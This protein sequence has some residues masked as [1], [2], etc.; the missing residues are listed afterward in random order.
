MTCPAQ[1]GRVSDTTSFAAPDVGVQRS[2]PWGEAVFKPLSAGLELD[3]ARPFAWNIWSIDNVAFGLVE[4]IAVRLDSSFGAAACP[5]IGRCQ[6]A[7]R[8]TGRAR[9][10]LWRRAGYRRGNYQTLLSDN[11]PRHTIVT[12]LDFNGSFPSTDADGKPS[13]SANQDDDLTGVRDPETQLRLT[14]GSQ[15]NI[16]LYA[17]NRLTTTARVY[18]WIDYNAD[19]VF[20]NATERAQADVP[21]VSGTPATL[22][23]VTLTFP[24]VPSGFTGTTYA[25]FRLSTDAAAASPVGPASDGEVQDHLVTISALGAGTAKSN[26]RVDVPNMLDE[27]RFGQSLA[28]LG[29]LDGDGIEDLAVGAH[30][31]STVGGARGAVHILFMNADQTVKSETKLTSGRNGAPNLNDADFFGFS[32]ANIGDF[33]NDGIVD[34]AV[35][36][37]G[38]DTV[39]TDGG[40]FYVMTLNRD[41]T[42]KGF[43][44]NLVN[45]AQVSDFVGASL[46]SLGDLDGDG[47]RD[48]AV[49]VPGSNFAGTDRGVVLV[50]FLNANG[51]VKTLMGLGSGTGGAPN[52]NDGD[53][54]GNELA[55]LGTAG[56]DADGNTLFEL[57]VGAPRDN[58]G[59]VGRGAVY[60]LTLKRDGFVLPDFSVKLASG[61]NGVPVLGDGVQFGVGLANFGF[62]GGNKVLAVGADGD[63]VA[64]PNRGAVYL[65]TLNSANRVA[66]NGVRKFSSGVG[67]P[68]LGDGDALGGAIVALRDVDG[69]GVRELA[70][71]AQ[72][73]DTGGTNRGTVHILRL[74]ASLGV[75]SGGASKIVSGVSGTPAGSRFGTSTV[76]LGDI[77][78]DGVE[79]LAVGSQEENSGRGAV[80]ILL[81]DR[82]GGVKSTQVLGGTL[83][84]NVNDRFGT[85]LAKLPDT[86]GDGVSELVVGAPFDDTNGTD[87]GAVYLLRL[88]SNGTLKSSIKLASGVTGMPTL[89]NND[90]FGA[91]LSAFEDFNTFGSGLAV[92]ATGDNGFGGAI[93]LIRSPNFLVPSVVGVTK[94]ASGVNGGPTLTGSAGFGSS[95]ASIGDVD[96]DG[97]GDLAVGA[98]NDGGSGAVHILFLNNGR[99]VRSST[100][101]GNGTNG[102]PVLVG[103]PNFG[104]S[105]APLGDID[106][107]GVPDVAIGAHF[108]S[109]GGSNRGAVFV[110][111]LQRNGAAKSVTKIASGLGGAPQLANDSYFGRTIA[112]L[113]DIN[114]D[115]VR[116]L[117]VG[118]RGNTSVGGTVHLLR[119]NA[120]SNQAPTA[121]NLSANTIAENSASGTA[122][123]T[124]TT[125][126]PDAGNTFTYS[127]LNPGVNVDNQAFS[128]VGNQLRSFAV[129]DFEAKASYSVVVRTTDQ[130]GLFFDRTFTVNVTNVNETPTA[131]NLSANT[132]AENSVTGTVIGTFTSTDPDAGNT[133]TY[134]L[135]NPGVNIDN[136][137]FSIVGNQLRSFAVFNFETKST[138]SVVVRTTDQGGLFFDRTFTVN[139]TDVNEVI[140]NT[141]PALDASGNPFA[142]LG[143][144][145]R[146]STEMRQGVLV[147]DILARGAGGNPISDPDAGALRG[148]ALTAVDQTLGN[149]QY[150]LVT[151]NPQES[152]WVNVDAAGALSDTS[153]LLLPTTARLRFTTGR[154]P[155]H[156][157]A[158]FFLSV[159]SKL[160]AGLTFRAWDQTSG[161][162]GGRANTSTNGGTSAFSAATE[163]SKVYFEVRLFRSFNPNASLNVYTLEAEFNALTSGAFQDRSTNAFTGFT[164]LLSPVPE[165]GTS[166]LF[167][168]YFGIQFNDDGTET[169]MGYRYLTS[170]GAE[171]TFLES[172]GPASKRP[173]REGT[174]F[175]ELGV[176]NGTATI[177]YVFTTQ[178]PGTSQLTQIYRT[179]NVN[180]PTRPPGTSEG[181]T[182]TSFKPQENGDHVYTTN[183]AFEMSKFGTWRIES[184][185]GFVRELNPNPVSGAATAAAVAA[186]TGAES[187]ESAPSVGS[188]TTPAPARV[189]SAIPEAAESGVATSSFLLSAS[190][191]TEHVV[192]L[193]AIPSQPAVPV[194]PTPTAETIRAVSA[195]TPP[196]PA[197]STS[198]S[199][200]ST[201]P[202]HL[203][204]PD[205]VWPDAVFAD[206]AFVTGVL[207]AILPC[208]HS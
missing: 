112:A 80:R 192:R 183:T 90:R 114:G 88:N 24:A 128:I 55:F 100:R 120:A 150:T 42:V 207:T 49:G 28:N 155:H 208:G 98:Y 184:T 130:G 35:G 200:A 33:D 121:L 18:G 199:V 47:V 108:E 27:A 50:A 129:F 16:A 83:G 171:A 29:D 51:T 138:Y 117:A 65:L 109:T 8:A 149:F 62:V 87:R 169:D 135:L 82:S 32:V 151:T 196:R 13:A 175:R 146:Q 186:V 79:D 190:G 123:G 5:P 179:D 140:P 89:A 94:I 76:S 185:R 176:S 180:K 84:L 133:F 56:T 204:S 189:R 102:G 67:L 77:D 20:D 203:N 145:S 43:V 25:R 127:L 64:G 206:L 164:V 156:A 137:A 136:Q 191:V 187:I 194:S 161:A 74:N 103:S 59:G 188:Q 131:L 11:G 38:D 193:V 177:G 78:G 116:D 86:D 107:D 178:Q 2:E 106:G 23:I 53:Q 6:R 142:I 170:N 95:I 85:S 110:L 182:P 30:L 153:A 157:S 63:S 139:I 31:D 1:I 22:P 19:G 26:T 134:S 3:V 81:M 36:A 93:Y 48:L 101:I 126:D 168:L 4:R 97:F 71:G 113:G 152:D 60:I 205:S 181:G 17:N 201:T 141:A 73:D 91:S 122:I 144:G 162:A 7:A 10:G 39:S 69:D 174:Y 163:T 119:L 96:G 118:A 125:T 58:T 198:A 202:G 166:A 158:P 99:Q 154:I 124:F 37:P 132:I 72:N 66:T 40:A 195:I 57:A 105:A 61:M 167:R 12:G 143:A 173:Q 172:I 92:G 148:I 44:K 14:V 160:D 111:R 75:K 197:A 159:E 46:A 34:L 45:T 21:A 70:V 41:G 9:R 115:G 104:V 68:T 147:S 54:F 15:P 52:L 165:L